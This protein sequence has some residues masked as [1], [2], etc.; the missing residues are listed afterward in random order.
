MHLYAIIYLIH[1]HIQKCF[2]NSVSVIDSSDQKVTVV[3]VMT[4]CFHFTLLPVYMPVDYGDTNS[5]ENFMA[6][7]SYLEALIA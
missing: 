3:N 1:I 2:D 6:T 7:Y 4:D 5:L